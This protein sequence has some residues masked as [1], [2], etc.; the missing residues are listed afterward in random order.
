[1]YVRGTDGNDLSGLMV[2]V[3]DSGK[4]P[5]FKKTAPMLLKRCREFYQDPENERAFQEWKARKE[6]RHEKA[7]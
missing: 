5:N 7:V 6:A 1:M 4:R 2:T 3:T